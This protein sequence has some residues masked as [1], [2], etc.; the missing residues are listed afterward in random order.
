MSKPIQEDSWVWVVVQD[1]G[2]DEQFLGQHD[3]E[4]GVSFIPTFLEKD[5]AEQCLRYLSRE[6]G[7]VYEVQAV[8]FKELVK[9]SAQH[10]FMVFILNGAG[11][12][13]EK[14]AF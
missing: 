4:R 12:V 13:L 6:K 14:V 10:G 5:E 1:P 3:D 9:H 11:E 8:L 7:K 2:N